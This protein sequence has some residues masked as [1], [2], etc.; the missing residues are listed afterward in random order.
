MSTFRVDGKPIEIKA[1]HPWNL[2]R[3]LRRRVDRLGKTERRIMDSLQVTTR[4]S[5]M[6]RGLGIW[7]PWMLPECE[8]DR[9]VL[10]MDPR[11]ID[12]GN[13]TVFTDRF[14]FR[15][16]YSTMMGELSPF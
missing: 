6:S 8:S 12:D 16:M 15:M 5:P 10:D 1:G 11:M 14:Y 4:L 3:Y 9:G 2:P 7:A 13:H